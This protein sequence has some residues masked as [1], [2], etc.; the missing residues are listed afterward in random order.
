MDA[1]RPHPS[2]RILLASNALT[3][4]PLSLLAARD[5]ASPGRPISHMS[6]Q[7]AEVDGELE[8]HHAEARDDEESGP[9]QDRSRDWYGRSTTHTH[10]RQDRAMDSHMFA[11]SPLFL[12]PPFRG[13]DGSRARGEE[14]IRRCRRREENEEVNSLGTQQEAARPVLM[15]I[16]AR[17]R[18]MP[19]RCI[20]LSIVRESIQAIHKTTVFDHSSCRRLEAS[21]DR[22]EFAAIASCSCS[23]ALIANRKGI[24]VCVCI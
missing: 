18:S 16:R 15:W 2:A 19:S 20:A 24:H 4:L 17:A 7:R 6:E 23:H 12:S 14:D 5:D 21:R 9:D 8:L 10:V 1:W 3:R 11:S 13:R 22:L